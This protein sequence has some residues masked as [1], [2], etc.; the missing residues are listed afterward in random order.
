MNE[1]IFTS[2]VNQSMA[3]ARSVFVKQLNES[4]TLDSIRSNPE[5]FTESLTFGAATLLISAFADCTLQ[6]YHKFLCIVLREKGID[7]S[8]LEE[9]RYLLEK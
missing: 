3:E 9:F 8:D 5:A 4:S 7:I 2:L 6:N 1:S